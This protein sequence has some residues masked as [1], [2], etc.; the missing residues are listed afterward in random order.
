MPLYQWTS[1]EPGRHDKDTE[2]EA[3]KPTKGIK[4]AWP[5]LE[6]EGD[7]N[8]TNLPTEAMR[9]EERVSSVDKWG[10]SPGTVQGGRRKK[11]SISSTTTTMTSR[12]TSH[13]PLSRET[14]W[15]R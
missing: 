7:R 2:E 14:T 6:R 9:R 4:D 11:V 15:P 12:S 5:R 13:R 3:I 10:T 1:I 8:L